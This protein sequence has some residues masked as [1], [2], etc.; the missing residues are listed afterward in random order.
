MPHM[1]DV[2]IEGA[3][4]SFEIEMMDAEAEVACTIEQRA[5]GRW[6]QGKGSLQSQS[7]R[8][9]SHRRDLGGESVLLPLG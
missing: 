4:K 1:A 3:A 9:S 2:G 7:E 8:Q 6:E 5:Q